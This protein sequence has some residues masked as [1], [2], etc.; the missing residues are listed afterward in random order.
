VYILSAGWGLIRSD[1]L[2]PQYD[3]T[4]SPSADPYKRRR[5]RD[6]YADYRHLETDSDEATMFFG[7]KAY[8][9]LFGE[10]TA[11]C[12]CQRV[13]YYNSSVPPSTPGCALVRYK[14]RIQTNWHYDCVKAFLAGQL[15]AA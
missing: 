14:T 3:I 4:F 15:A 6:P 8:L 7:G 5:P 1:F 13:V 9:P 12:R 10:L 11:G 2:L